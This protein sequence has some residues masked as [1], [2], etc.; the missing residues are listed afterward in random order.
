V[1]QAQHATSLDFHDAPGPQD[2]GD[3]LGRRQ[4]A[5][6]SE[7]LISH[8]DRMLGIFRKP[9]VIEAICRAR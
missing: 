3:N 5:F 9:M 4:T 6:T 1:W 8:D 7:R 2:E